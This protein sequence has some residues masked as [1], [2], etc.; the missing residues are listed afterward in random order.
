MYK[1]KPIL[2]AVD[3]IILGF[4]IRD[5]K[6]KLLTV[7]RKV[8]PFAGSWSL[9]GKF[10]EEDEDVDK[11]ANRV[12]YEFTGLKDIFLEQ[13]ACYGDAN[14]DPGGRAISISYWSLIQISEMNAKIIEQHDAKWFAFDELPKFILDHKKMV[15][16]VISRLRINA[17]LRPIGF[18]LLPKKFTLPQLIALYEQIYQSKLDDRNFRKK[19][20]SLGILEKLNEKDKST[21]KKGSFLYSFDHKKYNE[22][23][24]TKINLGINFVE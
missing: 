8:D 11:A 2:V 23:T 15:D 7:R 13:H 21:S 22:L 3:C 9:M 4:D 20:L 19:I 12:L 1:G 14:R 17:S 24:Q 6:L 16:D 18:K 10:V 5:G